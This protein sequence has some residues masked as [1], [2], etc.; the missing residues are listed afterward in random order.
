MEDDKP[1]LDAMRASRYA[2][3]DDTFI[4]QTAKRLGKRP[5][6]RIGDGRKGLKCKVKA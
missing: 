3:G 5:R 6:S 4:D 1:I 2:I